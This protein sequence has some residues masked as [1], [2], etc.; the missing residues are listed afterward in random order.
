MRRI[1]F[2]AAVLVLGIII[3]CGKGENKYIAKYISEQGVFDTSTM[4]RVQQVLEIKRD[5]TW[6]L[7]PRILGGSSDGEWKVDEDGIILHSGKSRI[8]SYIMRLEK[9]K[10]IDWRGETFLK[11]N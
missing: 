3:G 9:N 1:F 2:L 7:S 10:L 8:P 4:K 5:R 11:Q 6:K